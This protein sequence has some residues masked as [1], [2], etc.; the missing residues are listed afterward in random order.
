M[1]R[2]KSAKGKF[3]LPASQLPVRPTTRN[4]HHVCKLQFMSPLFD[5]AN[6]DMSVAAL[7]TVTMVVDAIV[8]NQEL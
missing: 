8:L 7:T 1:V 3:I 5:R 2:M 4:V 6:D